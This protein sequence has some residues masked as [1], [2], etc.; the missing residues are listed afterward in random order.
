MVS[1]DFLTVYCIKF[2]LVHICSVYLIVWGRALSFSPSLSLCLCLFWERMFG[3]C[4]CGFDELWNHFNLDITTQCPRHFV[5]FF[6]SIVTFWHGMHSSLSL[7]LLFLSHL[8]IISFSESLIYFDERL[9]NKSERKRKK[10]RTK[11]KKK[12]I[13]RSKEKKPKEARNDCDDST[14]KKH[15]IW[16]IETRVLVAFS[17]IL[18]WFA[19]VLYQM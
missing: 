12:R 5:L 8:I 17:H 15:N 14:D 16:N 3:V 6:I 13:R 7:S 18:C 4:A 2:N 1:F 10:F 9:Q 11:T 19:I